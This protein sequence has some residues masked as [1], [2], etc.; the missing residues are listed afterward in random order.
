MSGDGTVAVWLTNATRTSAGPGPGPKLLPA[1]EAGSL[2]G[3]RLA[4]FGTRP[5]HGFT[6][7]GKGTAN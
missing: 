7:G 1:S 5:P 2:V 3:R 4:C 6:G